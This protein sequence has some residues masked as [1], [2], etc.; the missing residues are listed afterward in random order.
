MKT[1]A[2]ML[3]TLIISLTLFGTVVVAYANG[4]IIGPG[5]TQLTVTSQ[6]TLQPTVQPTQPVVTPTSTS[7][8]LKPIL[9]QGDDNKPEIALTIDDGPS[10][11]YTP[12]VLSILQQYGIHASF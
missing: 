8:P 12:Q 4:S 5:P 9:S 1:I 6:P 10:P 7:V 11:T 2:I 3:L